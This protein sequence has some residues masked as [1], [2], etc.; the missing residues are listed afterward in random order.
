MPKI[1]EKLKEYSK[2]SGVGEI[3]R[4]YFV[5]NAFDGALTM[6]GV[7]IGAYL[8][9]I[10]SP[11]PIISAG[12]A[13]SL[14]MAISGVSGAYMTERAERIR[15]LKSLERSMLKELRK[16]IHY[17]SHRFA[18]IVTSLTD[19]L[20]P[21][22]SAMIV[23]SPFFLLSLDLLSWET[24][25]CLSIILTLILLFSIGVYLAK[26]SEESLIVYGLQMLCIGG[27]TAI[28]CILVSLALGGNVAR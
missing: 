14:A 3:S 13:G 11:A 20:S 1:S 4:R 15:K 2:I 17:K 28:L 24:A 19:G 9:N 16:S 12:L 22:L 27:L 25:F 10:R 18:V 23:L 7:I 5:M 21:F 6:L 8:S 26:V